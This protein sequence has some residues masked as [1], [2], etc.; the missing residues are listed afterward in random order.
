MYYELSDE[1]LT[2]LTQERV[3]NGFL[4]NLLDTSVHVD[5]FSGVTSA[6]RVSDG[7]LIV[8]DSI[9]GELIHRPCYVVCI[10]F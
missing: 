1:D 10:T 7:A 5:Y 9:S 3:G 6:L 2:H 8:V 4:I